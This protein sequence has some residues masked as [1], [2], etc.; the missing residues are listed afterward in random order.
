MD[1][2]I[3]YRK[4]LEDTYYKIESLTTNYMNYEPQAIGVVEF[5]PENYENIPPYK[6]SPIDREA[7]FSR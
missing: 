5:R 7:R 6:F 2:A 1:D 3:A 4:Q